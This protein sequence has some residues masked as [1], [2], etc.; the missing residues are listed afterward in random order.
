MDILHPHDKTDVLGQLQ[1]IRQ[2]AVDSDWNTGFAPM[3]GIDKW[4]ID[5]IVPIFDELAIGPVRFDRVLMDIDRRKRTE[6]ELTYLA[7]HDPLTGLPNRR[8]FD[9][10]LH[11]AILEAKRK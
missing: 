11:T 4:V 5:Y 1:F 7:F 6:A 10:Q 9:E 8:E 3:M 2:G